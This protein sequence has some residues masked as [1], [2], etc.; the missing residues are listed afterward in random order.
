MNIRLAM[1]VEGGEWVAYLAKQSTMHG[2]RKLGSISM[3]LVTTNQARKQAF[4]GMMKEAVAELAQG[5]GAEIGGWN[6][7]ARAPERERAG[8]A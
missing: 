4:M 6:M 2:A 5:A 8:R 3:A 1:R 7:P